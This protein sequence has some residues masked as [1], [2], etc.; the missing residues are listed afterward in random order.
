MIGYALAAAIALSAAVQAPQTS[1]ESRPLGSLGIPDDIA[2]AI[3][4]YLNCRLLGRGARL[5]PP[6][7]NQIAPRPE[8]IGADCSAVRASSSRDA[9]VLL[10]G[11]RRGEAERR[12]HIEQAL[13]GI[14]RFVETI[15]PLGTAK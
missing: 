2:P 7:P 12:D 3:I 6:G 4:P 10:S 5:G 14:D 13:A 9:A 1:V 11:D 8:Q 15:P